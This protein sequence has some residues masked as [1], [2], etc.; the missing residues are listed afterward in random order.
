[1]RWL[2]LVFGEGPLTAAN[3]FNSQADVVIEARRAADLV[4]ATP[5]DRPEDIEP[6]PLTGR[7]Y[8]VLHLQRA[9][10][11]RDRRQC[12]RARQPGQH[13]LDNKYGQIV[14]IVPPLVERQARSHRARVPLG[15]LPAR[16]AIR[17]SP[18]T[19]PS[20]RPGLSER[21]ALLPRQRR[22]RSQ[23]PRLD[24]D[25]RPGRRD[26]LLPTASTAPTRAVPAAASRGCSSTA[27]AGPRSAGRNSRPTARRCSSPSSIRRE[28]KDST[29]DKPTHALA[30]FQG[31][32]AATPVGDRHLAQRWR[33]G[34]E[35]IL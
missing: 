10:Q 3:G 23:G 24:L 32:H 9:A 25:R 31:R 30:G 12:A 21:L 29:F 22:L 26:R 1:M 27:R 35:L 17:R 7:I 4:G 28:E 16:R 8:V 13:R 5:M 34:G 14:E 20:T 33:R 15:V 18:S 6:N 11:A 2:P 19:A